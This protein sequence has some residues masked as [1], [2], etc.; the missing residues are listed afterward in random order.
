M[1]QKG[2]LCGG[3]V[4]NQKESQRQLLV[5]SVALCVFIVNNHLITR[6]TDCKKEVPMFAKCG[7]RHSI[8]YCY[9]KG[10]SNNAGEKSKNKSA[11]TREMRVEALD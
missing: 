8:K 1:R 11:S 7:R 2:F 3:A 9:K 5:F 6:E 4:L 10:F